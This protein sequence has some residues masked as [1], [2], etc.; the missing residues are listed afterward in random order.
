MGSKNR[1][2]KDLLPIILKD[3]KEEQF[4]VEPFVGGAN[5]IDKIG[6]NRIGADNNKYL[7]SMWQELQ[8]GWT[9]PTNISQ[10][11]YTNIRINKEKHPA[12][13]VCFVG[14]LCAFGGKW[15]GGYAKNKKGDNYADRGSR[16][17]TK[18]I[19]NLQ[20]VKFINCSYK[21]LDIPNESII[22]CDPPYAGT[23]KYKDGFN[24]EEFWEWCRD[25]TKTGHQVFISEYNAPNDFICV[26]EKEVKTVLNKNAQTDKRI[27][28][29]FVY[30][31]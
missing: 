19:K 5:M 15:F 11:D 10:E 23:T 2:S 27:E 28:K 21:D 20:D 29:L 12:H 22:Y 8:K 25:M 6:G 24:H 3:K 31:E 9:P 18:Q 17:L 7:I 1:I 4:Y 26:F 30:A 16:V 13:L 14:F